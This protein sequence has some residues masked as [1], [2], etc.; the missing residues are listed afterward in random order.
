MRS[1][2]EYGCEIYGSASSLKLNTLQA[3]GLRI[4]MGVSTSTATESPQVEAGDMSLDLR[5]PNNYPVSYSVLGN[6]LLNEELAI[7]WMYFAQQATHKDFS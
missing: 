1:R 3:T 7:V 4:Y 2:I 6:Y 5:R